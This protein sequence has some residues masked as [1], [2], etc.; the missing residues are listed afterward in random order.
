MDNFFGVETDAQTLVWMLIQLPNDLQN[1]M[2]T[3]WLIYIHLFDF[4]IRLV[5]GERNGGPDALSC[6]GCALEDSEDNKDLNGFFDAMLY[7]LT[8]DIGN[9]TEDFMVHV[10][11]NEAEYT[12]P[13]LD[14]GRFLETAQHPDSLTDQQFAEFCKKALTFFVRNR[15]L[16][17]PSRRRESVPRRV[18]VLPEQWTEI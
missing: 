14:I 8:V 9:I 6:R 17:K 3:R 11:F 12:G 1:A 4:E 16:F 13:D 7:R 2:M 15:I 5:R 10:W 18:V